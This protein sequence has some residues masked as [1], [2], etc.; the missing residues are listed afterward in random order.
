MSLIFKWTVLLNR[1]WCCSK[2]CKPESTRYR[3]PTESTVGNKQIKFE[4]DKDPS[5]D[6]C[7]CRLIERNTKEYC[8][9]WWRRNRN[10]LAIT[11]CVS[12][13][14]RSCRLK[15]AKDLPKVTT[16]FH[17]TYRFATAPRNKLWE[18]LQ[19]S[20][21]RLQRSEHGCGFVVNSRQLPVPLCTPEVR[22]VS[23]A[24]PPTEWLHWR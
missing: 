4:T 19:S 14:E 16:D 7:L 17:E 2:S 18:A 15:S 8:S 20:W 5:I 21:Q 11:L 6:L 10:N 12:V 23:A 9:H 24:Y 3:S 1:S 22:C 13:S